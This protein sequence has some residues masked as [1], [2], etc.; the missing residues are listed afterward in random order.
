MPAYKK[1]RQDEREEDLIRWSAPT[2]KDNQPKP[3]RPPI[4][5]ATLIDIALHGPK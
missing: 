4:A 1:Q 3:L 5:T 2:L